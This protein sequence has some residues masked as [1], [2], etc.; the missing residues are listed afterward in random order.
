MSTAFTTRAKRREFRQKIVQFDSENIIHA[1][2]V[3]PG[4]HSL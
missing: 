1:E 2:W 4:V 3:N